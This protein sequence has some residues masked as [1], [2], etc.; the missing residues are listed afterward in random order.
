MPL[1]EDVTKE[2]SNGVRCVETK[3]RQSVPHCCVL[4]KVRNERRRNGEG[5]VL[6]QE[7]GGPSWKPS[8]WE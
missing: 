7:C 5:E 1:T 4:R 8:E 2:L 6:E 3:V